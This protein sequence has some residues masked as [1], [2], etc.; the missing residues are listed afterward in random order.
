[1]TKIADILFGC[2]LREG[3]L[4]EFPALLTSRFPFGKFLVLTDEESALALGNALKKIPKKILLVLARGTTFCLCSA[5]PTGLPASWARAGRRPRRDISRRRA[6]C[7]L[8]GR[9]FPARRRGCCAAGLRYALGKAK[10]RIPYLRPIS[11]LPLCPPCRRT[12]GVWRGRPAFCRRA[13][14]PSFSF[15]ASRRLS[16]PCAAAQNDLEGYFS[17]APELAFSVD[18]SDRRRAAETIF[19]AV[20]AAE[21]CFRSGFPEG[22]IFRLI[23]AAKELVGGIKGEREENELAFSCVLSL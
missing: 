14:F 8:S 16:L 23:E 17:A 6:R 18:S 3:E 13:R 4:A 1:M 9:V 5:C 20:S 7:R 2:E 21:Y 19:R 12:S 10:R 11:F 22:E 15:R